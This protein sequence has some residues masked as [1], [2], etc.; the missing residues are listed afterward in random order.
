[1]QKK[2]RNVS[3]FIMIQVAQVNEMFDDVKE[4]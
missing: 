2:M 4:M 1:M 3:F